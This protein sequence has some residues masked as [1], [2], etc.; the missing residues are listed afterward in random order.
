[1]SSKDNINNI[2]GVDEMKDYRKLWRQ[3]VAEFLGTFFYI[4]IVLL[5]GTKLGTNDKATIG[6]ANGLLVAS[7]VQIIGHVSGG[8]INPAITISAVILNHIKLLKAILYI[9]VQILGSMTGAFVT[10]AITNDNIRDSMGIVAPGEGVDA[11]KAFGIEFLI[12]Y[13]LVSVFLSVSDPNKGTIGEGSSALAIGL[14]VTA[15]HCSCLGYTGSLNPIRAFGP[16]LVMGSWSLH[17]LYWLAPI[18][19]SVTAGFIY[20]FVFTLNNSL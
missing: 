3:L 19:A 18:A 16:A 1:M 10:Y 12:T 8:H 9:I 2:I 6:F 4:A 20:R 15:C 14:T 7:I 11:G 5:S 17:W 13:V